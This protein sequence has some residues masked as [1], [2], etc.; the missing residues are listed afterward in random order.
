MRL[1][2]FHRRVLSVLALTLPIVGGAALAGAAT[3]SA[4]DIVAPPADLALDP[5]YTQ[6]IETDG[7]WITSSSKVKPGTLVKAR[8][9][10][11][12]MLAH[13]PEIARELVRQGFRI[14]IMAEDET[15]MDLP[16]Q[17]DWDKPARDDIVLTPFER[18][19]YDTEIAPLTPYEYW[20]KRARG[21]GGLLTSGAEE[22]IQAVPGTR[23][24]GETILVHEFSHAMY[25]ALLEIG[26]AF[27]ALIHAAYANARQRG[28]WKDQYMENTIDEYWAE[29]TQFWFNS[30]F[31]AQMGDTL[32]RTDA[33]MA[34]RDPAL[35]VLLEQV[36]G[37]I[38]RLPDDPFWMHNAKA[39][40]RSPA[41]AD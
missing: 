7:L 34:A 3:A 17:R 37:P 1:S 30:N 32:V 15:T 27:D 39:K 14:A 16:E 28:T 6:A 19:N 23:Y 20:A 22:N 25:Q 31:P 35:A 2:S 4:A 5:F 12:A 40:P 13:R 10:V 21:M 9:M 38:H 8:N 26:P 29:G 24:F 33:E 36:Y 41:K 11:H 18:E